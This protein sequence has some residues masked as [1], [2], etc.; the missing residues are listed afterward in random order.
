[1]KHFFNLLH[2]SDNFIVPF[3]DSLLA[4]VLVMMALMLVVASVFFYLAYRKKMKEREEN[5]EVY[6]CIQT[7][8]GVS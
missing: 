5:R 8:I 3:S 7:H 2:I 1:M 6:L 4:V